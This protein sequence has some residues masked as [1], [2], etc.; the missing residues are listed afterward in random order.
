MLLDLT[1]S[2]FRNRYLGSYLGMIWAFINPMVTIAVFVFVFQVGFKAAPV[3]NIPFVLWLSTGI[4]PWFYFAEAFSQSSNSIVEYSFLVKKVV[5]RVSF[6]PLIKVISAIFIHLCFV[7]L[8]LVMSICFGFYPSWYWLQ[9]IYYLIASVFLLMGLSWISASLM[10]FARDVGNLIGIIIQFGFWMTPIFWRIDKI[11]HKYQII[12]KLNPVFYIV[13]GY[14]DSII[15]KTW[16]W[17]RPTMS[18]YFWVI[19][20]AIFFIGLVVFKKTKPHFADVL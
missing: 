1:K 7:L 12:L 16:F 10:V 17:Q 11:P 15:F 2:D 20:M 18:I 9:I 6:L 14:R 3:A 19:S 13:Q 4:I 8:I 5:F